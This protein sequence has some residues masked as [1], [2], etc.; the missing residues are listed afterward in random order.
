MSWRIA[1]CKDMMTHEAADWHHTVGSALAAHVEGRGS[2]A[3]VDFL[4]RAACRT[5]AHEM[6]GFTYVA[7]HAGS[8]LHAAI[9]EGMLRAVY[10]HLKSHCPTL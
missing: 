9:M 5:A 10:C 3:G 7:G 8:T 1:V 2:T 6:T 4:A